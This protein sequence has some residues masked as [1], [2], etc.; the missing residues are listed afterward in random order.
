MS[1]FVIIGAGSSSLVMAADLSLKGFEVVLFEL[2]KFRNKVE[3]IKKE[4]GVE[5]EGAAGNGK[6]QFPAVTH[7]EEA[8]KEA[9]VIVLPS[10]GPE[11]I[12]VLSS[13]LHENQ[14]VVIG[15]GYFE[16][17]ALVRRT[18]GSKLLSEITVSEMS[19]FPY[20]GI[21]QKS[22]TKFSVHASK[23][24]IQFAAYPAS[25]TAKAI[26]MLE[27]GY[28]QLRPAQN[29]LETSLNNLNAMLHPP[30]VLFNAATIERKGSQMLFYKEGVTQSVARAVELLDMERC[31]L[32]SLLGLK[33]ITA[34]EWL[35]KMY[36]TREETLFK[37]MLE[38]KAYEVSGAPENPAQW[39]DLDIPYGLCPMESISRILSMNT[40][41]TSTFIDFACLVADR[42]YRESGHTTERLGLTATSPK[43]LMQM[44]SG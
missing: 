1:D 2:E 26:H 43:R 11:H 6:G 17:L 24:I 37:S 23:D 27:K 32:V 20:A 29:I 5:I 18:S 44:A 13:N 39:L 28:P 8:F 25:K 16:A 33:P 15:R 38:C 22:P 3:P 4:G 19:M 14:I 10:P 42:R 40:P 35:Y 30:I 21:R 12:E 9:K 36:G 34:K 31:K 7:P 41:T